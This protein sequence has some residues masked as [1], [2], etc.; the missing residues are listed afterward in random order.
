VSSESKVAPV[1]GRLVRHPSAR[2]GLAVI[3][4]LVVA[5]TIGPFF[6]S[7]SCVEQL[8]I[9]NLKN[10]PPSWSHPFGTDQYSRDVLTRVLC[11]ARVSLAVATLAVLLS[12]T[13]G[14]AYGLIAGYAGGRL[15]NAMMRILDGCLSIPRVLLLIAILTLWERVPI[16][17]LIVLLGATG[18]F[19]V[20]RLVR[21][22]TISAKQLDYVAAARAIGASDIRILWRHLLPNVIS[23]VIV[24]ATLAVGNVIAL[25]AGLS[26]LGIGARAP[27]ASWGS[28][29]F[30]GV[31]SGVAFFAGNWWVVLF[32][33]IAIVVTV[34]AFNV[35]GDALRDVLDPRQLH[36]AQPLPD[37]RK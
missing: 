13:L 27:T 30:D 31:E 26:Y 29:F 12:M 8:D 25:E 37:E 28:I 21:A 10:A 1:F 2:W 9:V 32:P 17:G 7:Y 5:A 22:E 4:L 6:S 20:S 15:D 23:P 33:G 35:L 19:G 16:G 24:A 36:L 11:G 34:L 14:T 18:W 3:V